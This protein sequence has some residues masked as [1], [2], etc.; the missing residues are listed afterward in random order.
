MRGRDRQSS[1]LFSYVGIESRLRS[2]H[3][4]RA[5]KTLV[6]EAL[7]SLSVEFEAIYEDRLGRPSIPPEHLLRAMLLQAFYSVRS[8]RQLMERLEFDLLFRWFVGLSAD[9]PA[10][11]AS[12]FSKNRERLLAGRIAA[13]FF[14]AVIDNRRVKHLLSTQH[15]SVDGTLIEAW[16]GM[17]SFRPNNS[18][19]HGSD[20]NAAGDF[21]GEKRS[22]ATHVSTID[23]DARLYR[24]GKGKPAQLCYMGHI[25][26]ENRNG[27]AVG[28]RLTQ[29]SGTAEREAALAMVDEAAL[30]AGST[31]G[32]DK[33]YNAWPFKQALKGR[34]LV[35]HMALRS[36]TGWGG[37]KIIPPPGFEASQ[38]ARKRVE[39][40]FGW[41]KTISGLAKTKFRGRRRIAQSF[42][43]A[44]AA[45]NLIRLPKL[46][47]MGAVT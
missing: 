3:P 11:D 7:G 22:N 46:L 12:T 41:V 4:L 5:I 32:A 31:L 20:G 39:Q 9:E 47:S 13:K 17:K 14:A 34:H 2:D 44:V 21:R 42:D 30:N 8:E 19:R 29:T 15:F 1:E 26:M 18:E 40:I 37:V 24:K 6:D 36:D 23:C 43:L 35:P 10:W 38:R 28:T 45:Y 27:L 33:S 25:L 16:A